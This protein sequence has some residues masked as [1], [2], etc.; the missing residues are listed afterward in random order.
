MQKTDGCQVT[1]KSH[2][3]FGQNE[4]GQIMR[5]TST[6]ANYTA[7]ILKKSDFV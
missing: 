3:D 5:L 7:T 6:R 2:L 4:L 1:T